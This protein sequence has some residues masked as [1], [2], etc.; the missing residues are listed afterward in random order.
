MRQETANGPAG[1][2][3]GPSE[4]GSGIEPHR[5]FPNDPPTPSSSATRPDW[6]WVNGQIAFSGSHQ[7]TPGGAVLHGLFILSPDDKSLMH[8]P[9]EVDQPRIQYPSWCPDGHHVAV[10]NYANNQIL[11]VDRALAP[12]PQPGRPL[13]NRAWIWAG[14]S[15]VNP[16]DTD[17]VCM[18]AQLPCCEQGSN[19][20]GCRDCTTDDQPGYDQDFNTI[21]IQSL[22]K[23]P[24]SIQ[25]GP[26]GIGR[27]PW[28]SPHAGFIAFESNYQHMNQGYSIFV[29]RSLDQSLTPVTPLSGWTCSHAK[30]HPT[31]PRRLVLAATEFTNGG[32]R[33]G[34]AILDM[35]P[36][37]VE[38]LSIAWWQG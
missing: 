12:Q 8:V 25:V 34:I 13:T 17:E 26:H 5:L 4:P 29:Y 16:L 33:H 32:N 37:V 3:I 14:M 10:T 19:D 7:P 18:A 27:A 38:E 23:K 30:W 21:W 6:S 1:L 9:I 2:W 31:N 28:W 36:S 35:D 24:Y 20:L 11:L 22:G 15:S